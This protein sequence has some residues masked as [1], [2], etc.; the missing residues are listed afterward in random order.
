MTNISKT[1][2]IILLLFFF[3]TTIA[4]SSCK[5]KDTSDAYYKVILDNNNNGIKDSFANYMFEEGLNYVRNQDYRNAKKCFLKANKAYPNSPVILNALG[6]VVAMTEGFPDAYSFF[7]KAFDTD[8]SYI[9]TYINYG[10]YLNVARQYEDA[11]KIFYLGF[12]HKPKYKID[13][14]FLYMCLAN[15]FDGLNQCSQA[16]SF[17]DSA[18]Q[19]LNDTAILNKITSLEK[20]IKLSESFK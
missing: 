10:G 6:N 8:S 19:G 16:L 3:L 7:K 11:K 17:L 4:M 20:Q 1:L 15:S 5:Q 9:R 14:C 13:S 18:K 12:E 2:S